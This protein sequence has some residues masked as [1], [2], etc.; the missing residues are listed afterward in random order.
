M[1]RILPFILAMAMTPG[2]AAA[3]T[4]QQGADTTVL[5]PN[6]AA[7][8]QLHAQMKQ[9]HAQAR[10][11]ILSALTPAHRAMLANVVGQLAIAPTPNR[12]A[13][14]RTLDATLT[15]IEARNIVAVETAARTQSR[16]LMMSARAQFE[17]SMT[18]D[19]R[20]AMSARMQG[21]PNARSFAQRPIDPGKTL[22][23][24]ALGHEGRM[25]FGGHQ[26]GGPPPP[27]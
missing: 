7:M 16:T 19:Q 2:L 14:V 26:M 27:Q 9:I 8:E 23:D 12:D 18:P 24:L 11:Q 15:P 13:A 5:H 4:T 6:A 17:A 1:K 10:A 3:Q 25:G 21:H 22:L 20:A